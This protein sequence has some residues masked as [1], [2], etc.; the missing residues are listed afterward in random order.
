MR[1]ELESENEPESERSESDDE[2]EEES[3]KCL[4]FAYRSPTDFAA[5]SGGFFGLHFAWSGF[6]SS[7]RWP[8]FVSHG[9]PFRNSSKESES[10]E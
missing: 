8:V 5:G 10:D 9:R 2:Y 6:L 1:S 4:K 7:R 3:E